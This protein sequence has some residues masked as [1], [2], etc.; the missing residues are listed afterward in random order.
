MNALVVDQ[1]RKNWIENLSEYDKNNLVFID[2]SDVN[3]DLTRIYRRTINGNVI[4][5]R[6]S[7]LTLLILWKFNTW[8]FAFTFVST[9]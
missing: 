5:L 3:T 1:E 6:M 2:E 8:M 9:I 4:N 7:K